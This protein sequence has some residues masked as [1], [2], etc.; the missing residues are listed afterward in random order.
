MAHVAGDRIKETSTTTGTGTLT[1][2]GAVAGFRRV[3]DIPAVNNDTLIYGINHDTLPEWEVGLGT[4]LTGHLLARTTVLASSNAGALVNFSAGTKTV[5]NT[6]NAGFHVPLVHLMASAIP[7]AP[8]AGML[9]LYARRRA[10]RL[11]PEFIGPS[12]L[13]SA[14]QP[15]LFGNRMTIWMPGTGTTVAINFGVSWTAR[16]A[17]TGAAQAHPALANTN[18]LTAMRRATFGTGTTATGSSGI[19]SSATVAFR[20]NTDGRGG[21]FYYARLGIETFASDMRVMV[22]LSALNAALAGEPSAQNNSLIIGKDST[23]TNWQ[24]MARNGSTTTKT[25]VGLAMAAGQVLDFGMFCKANDNKV[26]VR[27]VDPTPGGAVYLDDVELTATL[28]VNTTFLYM[29]AQNQSTTGTTA[30]LLALIGK[31][32]ETDY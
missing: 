12:G 4:W 8:P 25:D 19:Q 24:V 32:L 22:G 5:I 30:K 16:N 20:G 26:T 14:L 1:M 31:Y 13:D 11:L 18:N 15:A 6:P 28:P 2:D 23:D 9:K 29:H 3:A 27:V 21:F 7:L 17:G 10:G